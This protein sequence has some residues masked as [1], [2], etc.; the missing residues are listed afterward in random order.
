[1]GVHGDH[2][3]RVS[4]AR[5]GVADDAL[6]GVLAMTTLPYSFKWAW[7]VVIDAFPSRGSAGAGRG[8]SSRRA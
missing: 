6:G 7:G 2:A 5:S 3:A 4:L 1:M 8:S